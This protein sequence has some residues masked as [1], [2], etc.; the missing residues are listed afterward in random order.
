MS[1][2]EQEMP[3]RLTPASIRT[4]REFYKAGALKAAKS[5]KYPHKP[6][7]L[8]RVSLW[9]GDITNLKIDSI[10]NAANSRLGGGAGVN[11]AIQAAAGPGL[12]EECLTLGGCETGLAKITKGHELPAK[13]V[14][15]AVGPIYSPRNV[16][17]NAAQ[18]LSCYKT[19][20][21]IAVQNDLK[22]TAFPSL[23][24]GIFGYP[25][26]DATHIALDTTRLFLDTPDGDKLDRVIFVVWSDRDRDVYRDL[27]PYYFPQEK[28]PTPAED[29]ASTAEE[30]PTTTEEKSTKA[31][32]KQTP[33]EEKQTPV[34]EKQTPVEEKPTPVET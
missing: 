5:P 10:V 18:L 15:H 28:E 3:P 27:I 32:E 2:S 8:D 29:K 31:E 33:V 34:E 14:I 16:E 1:D 24:T 6:A 17:T 21:E 30:K 25:I 19:S 23:S 26:E 12:L 7:L 4:L 22:H 13:H 9:Q 11:G 20:L